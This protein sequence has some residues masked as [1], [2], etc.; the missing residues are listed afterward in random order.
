[1]VLNWF[2]WHKTWHTIL[3]GIY[4]CIEMV[5][6]KNNILCFILRAR[7]LFKGFIGVFGIFSHKVV[8]TWFFGTKLGTQHYVVY[9]FALKLLKSQTI[10]ICLILRAKLLFKIFLIVCGTF[11]HKV[12]QTWFVWHGT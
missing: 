9:I 8:K 3:F 6:I 10:V 1:M 7:L 4:C 5:K 2:V 12:V 11:S